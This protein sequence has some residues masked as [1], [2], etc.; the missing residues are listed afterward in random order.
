MAQP[1]HPPSPDVAKMTDLGISE[2]L[3]GAAGVAAAV[4]I[5]KGAE[6]FIIFLDIVVVLLLLPLIGFYY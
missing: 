2:A 3:V 1:R 4:A 5:R 6:G